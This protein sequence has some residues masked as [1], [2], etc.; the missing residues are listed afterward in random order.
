MSAEV[1]PDESG[2][3][4]LERATL[5]L[6][7]LLADARFKASD[8]Q[9]E[10]LRY[11]AERRFNGCQ[12]SVKAYSIALDV[13]GR[14]SDFDASIDPIV[15]IEISRLR[16]AL[17]GY[18]SVFGPELG[19]AIHVPK[20]SYVTLFPS[21]SQILDGN[22]PT[23]TQR[24]DVKSS[25]AV[26]APRKH[27]LRRLRFLAFAAVAAITVTSALT[28]KLADRPDL[29]SKP[30]VRVSMAS[31]V[32]ELAGDASVTR[33]ALLTA[34][35]QFD[36]VV[37]TTADEKAAKD[38]SLYEINLKYYADS[39]D[40]SIVWQVV[41][42]S[43]GHLIKAGMERV[44]IEGKASA[45]A[46]LELAGAV[47]R[48]IASARG[49]IN[50][51]IARE[52]PT[53]SAGY[54]CVARA[55]ISLD[56][57][58]D[59]DRGSILKCLQRTLALDDK[60]P[61]VSAALARMY[62]QTH[63]QSDASLELAKLAVSSAPFSDRA[64]AA[65]MMARFANGRIDSAID[66]GN[67]A[68]SLNPYNS[69]TAAALSLVLFSGGYWKA[70]SDMAHDASAMD[71]TPANNAS[72]VLAL[73]AYR[74][75][76]WSEASMFAEQAIGGDLLTRSIRAAA[77]GELGADGA[78]GRF[79]DAVG[80]RSDFEGTFR[81]AAKVAGLKMELI[82]SLEAGLAKAGANV[83]AVASLSTQ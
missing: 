53:N 50:M 9:R 41:D 59:R 61:D 26:L 21:S 29:T 20:G 83:D 76:R 75:G 64:H 60:D 69:S 7:R 23:D 44:D 39:D 40:R 32:P 11:L 62:A 63:D 14:S 68:L 37:V 12:E 81:Q 22:D 54:A 52:A 24:E 2:E 31:A 18:Y 48:K 36:T 56:S 15:R 74:N 49:V 8:R 73:E 82:Q 19:V 30:I 70:A 1:C 25:G 57:G 16:T 80:T 42:A 79:R 78:A 35:T 71:E 46:R 43:D 51:L 65:L 4:T 3:V 33:D 17:D 55:A 58:D 45:T 6:E 27:R 47:A 34:L 77:L 28:L 10:I 66:A 72:W 13:L 67:K 38:Q 5:E